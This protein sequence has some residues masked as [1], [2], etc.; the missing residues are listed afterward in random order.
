MM[1]V[2][3]NPKMQII[4]DMIHT[5]YDLPDCSCGGCCHIVTDDDNIEDDNL[6][7]V[8]NY[9]KEPEQADCVDKELSSMICELML[10]LTYEQRVCLFV[11]MNDGYCDNGIN[12]SIWDEYFG[13]YSAE[14]VIKEWEG[15]DVPIDDDTIDAPED[16]K[17]QGMLVESAD[18]SDI[19]NH[20]WILYDMFLKVESLNNKFNKLKKE[21]CFIWNWKH[22]NFLH[23]VL[24]KSNSSTHRFSL[25]GSIRMNYEL[26]NI[27]PT[28]I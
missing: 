26:L 20:P 6:K 23:L 5:L 14:E 19:I 27:T 9:C 21:S 18:I 22:P 15:D 13:I 25:A 8:I 16:K 12:K 17:I 3:Y 2:K 7:F 10:Q 24:W 1:D 28:Y 11:M 4:V